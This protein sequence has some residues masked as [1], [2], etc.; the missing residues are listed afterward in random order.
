MTRSIAVL[1]LVGLSILALGCQ[2]SAG[3][4][5]SVSPIPSAA[6]SVGQPSPDLTPGPSA[7]PATSPST[8]P[9]SLTPSPPATAEPSPTPAAGDTIVVRAYFIL[10]GTRRAEG[11]VPVLREVPRTKAVATA[12]M[13]ELLTGPTDAERA[14]SPALSTTVPRGTRLLGITIERGI[15]TVDLSGEYESGG[16]SASTLARLGQVVYTLTQFPTVDK[17]SFRVDGRPV[18][19][20]GSEGIVLDGPVG[21]MDNPRFG[22][23][24]FEDVLPA[25]FVDRPAWGAALANRAAVTG[26]GNTFEAHFTYALLNG[27]GR[28]LDEGPVMATCGSGCRG[29]FEF[30]VN[31]QVS[32]SHWGTLRVIEGDESGQT[33]GTARD[34]PVWLSAGG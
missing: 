29:T 18:T 32:R 33:S 9:P 25:I 23:T 15:A 7:S 5:G 17:V 1:L 8:P 12:A 4:L 11:L 10:A 6:P 3:P 2:A 34:Y 30:T 28:V 27:S 22:Q 19:V 26:T 13:N 21:R 24:M 20:F 14:A 31:Y 16:G